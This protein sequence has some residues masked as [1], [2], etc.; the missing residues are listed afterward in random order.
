[1]RN[2]GPFARARAV[3]GIQM[4]RHGSRA[5]EHAVA[6]D[7]GFVHRSMIEVEKQAA[8]LA[9]AVAHGSQT[10]FQHGDEGVDVGNESW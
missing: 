1:M 5:G 6:G 2:A 7:L 4:I 3:P 8:M 10:R 9:H